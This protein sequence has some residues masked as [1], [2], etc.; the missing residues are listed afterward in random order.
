MNEIF[1]ALADPTRRGV[2]RELRKGE[3]SAGEL[4]ARFP[5][6]KSTLSGHFAVLKAA[7][8][9]SSE[10][11]GRVVLYRLNA[12]VFDE[13]LTELLELFRVG[14]DD[15]GGVSRLEQTRD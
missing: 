14:E 1:K 8:L 5:I 9:I 13:V 15:A 3:K 2:L 11:R 6:A 4:A 12:S 10:K 7:D